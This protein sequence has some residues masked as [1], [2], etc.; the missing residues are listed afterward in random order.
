[1]A[2]RSH[3]TGVYQT[4]YLTNRGIG[5]TYEA[6]SSL[7]REDVAVP[8]CR[9]AFLVIV[10]AVNMSL[11]VAVLLFA[12][13]LPPHAR[14]W[15]QYPST[16]SLMTDFDFEDRWMACRRR[17]TADEGTAEYM[18]CAAIDDDFCNAASKVIA[19]WQLLSYVFVP[20]SKYRF[21]HF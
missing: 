16:S 20:A 4:H 3:D 13:L 19:F 15:R 7:V 18:Y 14:R 11:S 6:Y 8:R 1:M 5:E 17:A 2:R 21:R 9:Y 10:F 12:L